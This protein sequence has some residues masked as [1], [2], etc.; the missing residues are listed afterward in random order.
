MTMFYPKS[1]Y[2]KLFHIWTAMYLQNRTNGKGGETWSGQMTIEQT[3][4]KAFC[5]TG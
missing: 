5:S 2:I 3:K 1:C 4:N